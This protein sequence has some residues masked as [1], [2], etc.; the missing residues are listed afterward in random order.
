MNEKHHDSLKQYLNDM[1]GLERDIANAVKIQTED[2]RL[3][4]FGELKAVLDQIVH[5]GE[6]RLEV[7]KRISEEEG[8]ALGAAVKE[9]IT[10][11]TGTL[12]GIYGKMREHPVSRM[13]RDDIVALE[14]ASVSY[15]ML[16]TLGLSIGHRECV[17]IAEQGIEQLPGLIVELTDLLPTIVG[18][19]LSGDAPLVNPAAVQIAQA[20]IRAAWKNS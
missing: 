5:N 18:A 9:G 4:A 2:E 17:V 11:I 10:A 8:G 6:A 12:A 13:V 1:I 16:L 20:S 19:E 3:L 14:V 15:G 7:L